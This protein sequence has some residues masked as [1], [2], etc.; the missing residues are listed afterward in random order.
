LVIDMLKDE[1]SKIGGKDVIVQVDESKFSRHSE[2]IQ[3]ILNEYIEPESILYTD[4]WRG[5][6]G[7][8]DGLNVQHKMVNHSKHFT[9]PVTGV[10]TNTIEDIWNSVKLQIA[11]RHM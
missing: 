2:T 5:Y 6:N 9:D 10:N 1:M 4:C 11:S 7:V 8:E 3:K